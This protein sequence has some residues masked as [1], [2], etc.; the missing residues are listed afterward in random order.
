LGFAYV[1]NAMQFNPQ[2]DPRS[3]GLVRAAYECLASA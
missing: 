3:A 1:M 2:G